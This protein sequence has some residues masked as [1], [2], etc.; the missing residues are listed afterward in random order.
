[1]KRVITGYNN[2]FGPWL[3][4]RIGGQWIEGRGH[5]IGLW[6]DGVGPIACCFYE[7]CN[8]ASIL[9]HLAGD[10]SRWMTRE[11]LWYCFYYPFVQLNVKKILGLV[12]STNTAAIRLDEHLGFTLEATL[13]DAAPNGDLLIYS[14][15]KDQCRWLSLKDKSSGKT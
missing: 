2:I 14:M 5:T 1:M 15:V 3:M 4:Q 7:S 11:F 8:G 13:K 9:G 10:G 12:E 6:Q